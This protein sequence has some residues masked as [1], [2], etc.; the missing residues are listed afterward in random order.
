V[1]GF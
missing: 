1:T